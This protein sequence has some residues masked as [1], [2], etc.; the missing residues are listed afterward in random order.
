MT[1]TTA[2]SY[3]LKKAHDDNQILCVN[4]NQDFSCISVGTATGYRIYHCDPFQ[5]FYSKLGDDVSISEMLFSTS[6]VALVGADHQHTCKN[7]RLINTKRETTICELNFYSA[8]LTVKMNRKRLIVVLKDQLFVYDISNMKLL[9]TMDIIPNPLAICALSSST[10]HCYLACQPLHPSSTNT[11]NGSGDL[12]VY[13][14]NTMSL[15]NIVQAHKSPISCVVMNTKGN[16]IA[17]ASEKGT[18]IRVFSIP[19]ANKIYQFRR[20]SYAARIYSISFNFVSTLLCV[21]SDTET[22]HIFRLSEQEGV[23]LLKPS[24]KPS[25]RVGSLLPDRWTDLWDASRH[26]ASLKL[27]HAGVRSFVGLSR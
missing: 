17:T 7:L 23:D 22:V 8:I 2:T 12:E 14:A 13:D 1:L 26:F 27:P 20:G 5:K 9:H 21:S 16:L 10:E 24:H 15:A 4:F 19:N 25:G 11:A 6:L 3:D 18:M